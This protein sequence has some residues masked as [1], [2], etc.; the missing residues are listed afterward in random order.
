MLKTEIN[1]SSVLVF[2]I[3]LSIIFIMAGLGHIVKPAEIVQRLVKSKLGYLATSVATPEILVLLSGIVLLIGGV[4]FLLGFKT[5]ISAA[6]L[7]LILI[8]ITVTVQVGN[9]EEMGPL[10][11]NIGLLG[12]L[13]FFLFNG[14]L[15]YGIDQIKKVNN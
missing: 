3:L 8:P 2:R 9:P 4:T 7:L 13:I 15:H 5:K 12:G 10:F 11:K 14:S 6:I 1:K